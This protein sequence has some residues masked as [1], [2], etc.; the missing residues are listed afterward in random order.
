MI[1]ELYHTAIAGGIA[2]CLNN[3][4]IKNLY[5]GLL[6]NEALLL[7]KEKWF[8]RSEFL[9][10]ILISTSRYIYFGSQYDK[11]DHL[12]YDWMDHILVHYIAK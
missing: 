2:R 11:L 9:A 4:P 3:T 1:G 5:G 12:L 10:G 6:L 7:I 8:I